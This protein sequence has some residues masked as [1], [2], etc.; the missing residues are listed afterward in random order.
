MG[1]KEEYVFDENDFNKY[2][3]YCTNNEYYYPQ[4]PIK[5]KL[6]LQIFIIRIFK[7]LFY[8]SFIPEVIWTISFLFYIYFGPIEANVV[9]LYIICMSL[10]LLMQLSEIKTLREIKLSN[11]REISRVNT[12]YDAEYSEWVSIVKDSYIEEKKKEFKKHKKYLADKEKDDLRKNYWM[13]IWIYFVIRIK[14]NIVKYVGQTEKLKRRMKEHFKKK[15]SENE[16]YFEPIERKDIREIDDREKFWIRH[17]GRANLD[18]KTDG[19]SALMKRKYFKMNIIPFEPPTNEEL[20]KI[21][22]WL[23]I[24]KNIKRD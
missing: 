22:K 2:V 10:F 7:I 16:F 3:E 23:K 5:E 12:K 11:H 18:N 8:L 1:L 21:R 14:D 4:T 15:Y 24:K 6:H 19:G 9:S 20:R 13:P 17:F